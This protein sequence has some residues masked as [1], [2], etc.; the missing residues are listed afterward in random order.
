MNQQTG[1]TLAIMFTMTTYGTELRRD[2]QIVWHA[3][4][5]AKRKD[6]RGEYEAETLSLTRSRI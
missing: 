3:Q 1:Q 2:K 5:A 6:G 4:T